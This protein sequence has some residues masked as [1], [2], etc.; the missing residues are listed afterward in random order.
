MGVTSVDDD[1]ALLEVGNKLLDELVDSRASLDEKDNFA[2][3]LELGAELLDRPGAND[4]GACM[5]EKTGV[6][7]CGRGRLDNT[8]RTYP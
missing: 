6:S 8:E 1:V 7:G 2:G 5:S 3:A 4:V